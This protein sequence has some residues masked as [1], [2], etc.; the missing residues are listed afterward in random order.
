MRILSCFAVL[1]FSVLTASCGGGGNPVSAS[2]SVYTGTWSGT[3]TSIAGR[4]NIRLVLTQAGNSL[5]GTYA[6]TSAAC[7]FSSGS[8]SGTV[9]GDTLTGSVSFLNGAALCGTFT[10]RRSGDTINGSYGCSWGDS[11]TWTASR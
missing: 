9:S 7:A 3:S 11:G 10:G 5:S 1:A 8:V 4:L 6:C 2:G